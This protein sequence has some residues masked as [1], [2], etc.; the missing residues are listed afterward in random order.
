[1]HVG[2]DEATMQVT[3]KLFATLVDYLPAGAKFNQVELDVEPD[4]TVQSLIDRFS[5]PPRQVHL[6]LVNGHY[7]K[8]ED[9]ATQRLR[10]GDVLAIWPP[11]AGG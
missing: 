6:V 9:R 7:L 2:A 3:F 11:I 5:L 4:T 1:M 8:T 10:V